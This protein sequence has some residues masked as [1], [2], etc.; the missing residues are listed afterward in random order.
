MPNA[1]FTTAINKIGSTLKYGQALGMGTY[2]RSMPGVRRGMSMA[3]GSLGFGLQA[4]QQALRSGIGAYRGA[5]GYAGGMGY[6]ASAMAGL[7]AGG[8]SLATSFRGATRYGKAGM[9]G[10]GGLGAGGAIAGADFLNPW[11]LGWGD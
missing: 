2:A 4:G 1:M 5:A 11:G 3:G 10:A 9:I 8:G 6:G 7:K